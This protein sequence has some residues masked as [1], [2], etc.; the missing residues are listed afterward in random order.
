MSMGI[1]CVRLLSDGILLEL[2]NGTACYVSA[3][4]LLGQAKKSGS[5]F[6]DYD[7]SS[8]L[9][10]GVESTSVEPDWNWPAKPDLIQ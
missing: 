10:T 6:F 5:I 3:E 2:Q 4:L 8:D 1:R 9:K 7:P